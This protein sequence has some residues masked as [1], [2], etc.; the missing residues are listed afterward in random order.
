MS[1]AEV[2]RRAREV[3]ASGPAGYRLG[4]VASFTAE[5]L[6]PFLIVEGDAIGARPEPWMGGYGELESL[7]AADGSALWSSQPDVV[8]IA[9]RIEDVEPRLALELPEIGAPATR[10][11]LD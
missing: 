8:W 6:R 7:I 5:L 10:A 11:R 3:S 4:V 1:P 2:L 9:L